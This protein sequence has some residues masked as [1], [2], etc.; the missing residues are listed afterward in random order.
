MAFQCDDF[1]TLTCNT[2]RFVTLKPRKYGAQVLQL[3][4][5]QTTKDSSNTV[6]SH[7]VTP[8]TP[9]RKYAR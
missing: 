5:L 1:V 8:V 2:W 6:L 3:Q 4:V 7:L 9:R